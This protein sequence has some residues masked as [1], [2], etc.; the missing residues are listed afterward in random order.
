MV[1]RLVV[2]PK[3]KS[4]EVPYF[5]G[6]ELEVEPEYRE[7][8]FYMRGPGCP[9]PVVIEADRLF[10]EYEQ[11]FP[12]TDD[13]EGNVTANAEYLHRAHRAELLLRRDLLMVISRP[14]LSVEI[15]DLL[16]NADEGVEV[17]RAT[18]WFVRPP[19]LERIDDADVD[20][21]STPD[22]EGEVERVDAT[23]V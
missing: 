12:R 22:T 9:V 8:K 15:A 1:E 13:D 14:I 19:T 2:V 7:V 21:D 10:A 16:A 5:A 11:N 6:S 4:Y 17:L 18:E 3:Y 20:V 23:G